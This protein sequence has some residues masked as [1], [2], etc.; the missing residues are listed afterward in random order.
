MN[1][2]LV[3]ASA[4]H[5]EIYA[6]YGACLA[7]LGVHVARSLSAPA[8][9]AEWAH[10]SWQEAHAAVRFVTRRRT[11][12]ALIYVVVELAL[13]VAHSYTLALLCSAVTIDAIAYAGHARLAL[14]RM[15]RPSVRLGRR[16][17]YLWVNGR[18]VRCGKAVL[19]RGAA[20]PTA[21]SRL[22]R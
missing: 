21:T 4:V 12:Y 1:A 5:T 22:D 3:I 9:N 2:S 6:V 18:W 17:G 7:L 13:Y 14:R 20:P 10:I 19:D 8:I 15:E 11:A 16:G